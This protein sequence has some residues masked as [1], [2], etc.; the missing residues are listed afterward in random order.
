MS[1]KRVQ[2]YHPYPRNEKNKHETHHEIPKN[3]AP[4]CYLFCV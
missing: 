2:W 3:I 1:L 4:F